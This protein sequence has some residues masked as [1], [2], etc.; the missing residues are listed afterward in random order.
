MNTR[1]AQATEIIRQA[2]AIARLVPPNLQEAAFNRAFEVLSAPEGQLAPASSDP[3]V[4]RA[5]PG[6]E[7]H[8]GGVGRTSKQSDDRAEIGARLMSIDRTKYAAQI[9]REATA[10]GKC[11]WVLHAAH[12]DLQIDGLTVV[13]I[14]G[15][16]SD[17]FR[18]PVKEP[19]I[20]WPL[21]GRERWSI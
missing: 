3:R 5:L 15:V 11:L 12:E 2:A 8:G 7:A 13:E 10:I 9:S 14:A 17:K 21:A 4:R 20:R 6:R 16:L 19:A 18:T 1:S